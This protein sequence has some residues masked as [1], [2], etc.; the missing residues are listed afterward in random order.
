MIITL[1]PPLFQKKDQQQHIYRVTGSVQK[2]ME[3]RPGTLYISRR[4]TDPI[5]CSRNTATPGEDVA[6]N[7]RQNKPTNPLN[8]SQSKE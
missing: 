4:L 1:N 3:A 2:S 5:I 8:F 7:Q 6:Q